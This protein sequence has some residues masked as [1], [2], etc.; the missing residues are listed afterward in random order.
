ME[1]LASRRHD[2][3]MGGEGELRSVAEENHGL[4]DRRTVMWAGFGDPYISEQLILKRW[5]QVHP[6]VYYL[7]A[8]PMTWRSRILAAVLAAGDAA[9]VS[10]RTAG[11]LWGLEGFGGRVIEL[12]VPFV[13]DPLPKGI[14]VHRTRRILPA[15][16]VEGIPTTSIERTLL[17]LA[18]QVSDTI[19]EKALMSALRK[20]LTSP[21]AIAQTLKEQGGRGVRGTKRLRRVL[22]HTDEGATGSIAEVEA[23][24]LIRAAPIPMP[25]RQHRVRLPNGS[26][27]YPDFS[28][29]DRMK[30]IEV[31]GFEA[32][33][34]PEQLR[35]D[36]RRQNMLLDLGWQ[37]RRFSVDRIRHEAAIVADEITQFVL[38]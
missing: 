33:G 20:D 29:P 30:I 14:V 8:T 24:Q 10:H 9:L 15:A 11:L 1:K 22:L 37:I 31:D 18:S 13:N 25:V 19:L 3:A 21:D 16:D 17:D 38:S 36:L 28:W 26:N 35:D 34:S 5:A 23:A 4:V 6:G 12:T 2:R 27:A 32:H 7:N